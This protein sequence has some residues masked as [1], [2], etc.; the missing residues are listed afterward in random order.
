MDTTNAA[1]VELALEKSR[2]TCGTPGANM[3]EASALAL[4]GQR[5]PI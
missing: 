4:G 5:V 3:E 1:R 2:R